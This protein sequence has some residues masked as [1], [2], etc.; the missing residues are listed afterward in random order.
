MPPRIAAL[1]EWFPDLVWEPLPYGHGFTDTDLVRLQLAPFAAVGVKEV[2][3]AL[4][5]RSEFEVLEDGAL[6]PIAAPPPLSPQLVKGLE[7][8]LP[9]EY[10]VELRFSVLRPHP[11]IYALDPA[12]NIRNS[13]GLIHLYKFLHPQV[14]ANALCAYPPHYGEWDPV[15]GDLY[16]PVLWTSAWLASYTI[17][18]KTGTWWGPEASH[19]LK[20]IWAEYKDGPCHCGSNR[21][22]KTC[23]PPSKGKHS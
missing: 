14:M 17:W 13:R 7:R 8:V 6:R 20:E 9:V 23:H 2:A 3:S 12:I 16:F 15:S 19:D 11:R 5:F 4:R 22:M 18:R 1:K 10:L 21:P